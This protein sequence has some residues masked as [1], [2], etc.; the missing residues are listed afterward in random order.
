MADCGCAT[1][2]RDGKMCPEGRRLMLRSAETHRNHMDIHD[3]F[4]GTGL[5]VVS[6]CTEARREHETAW[7]MYRAHVEAA[8]GQDA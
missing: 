1:T 6:E 8:R 7:A 2:K 4:C 3:R 5:P